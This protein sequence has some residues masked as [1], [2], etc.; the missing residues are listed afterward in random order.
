MTMW[1]NPVEKERHFSVQVPS[2][3]TFVSQDVSPK[4]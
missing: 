4:Q 1:E 3:L 2:T